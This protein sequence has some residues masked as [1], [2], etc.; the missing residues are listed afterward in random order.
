[1]NTLLRSFL[2]LFVAALFF[3]RVLWAEGD[4]VDP[5]PLDDPLLAAA[6]LP[7]PVYEVVH[8]FNASGRS[9]QG[10]LFIDAGMNIHGTT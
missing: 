3:P 8:T 9:P 2:P 6:A 5:V 1:M 7:A 4:A 10:Q